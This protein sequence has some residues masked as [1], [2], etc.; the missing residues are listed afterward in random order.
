ML[1]REHTARWLT[2]T[3]AVVLLAAGLLLLPPMSSPVQAAGNTLN[4]SVTK[5][6]D[7]SIAL[8][9]SLILSGG[10]LRGYSVAWG[11]VGGDDRNTKSVNR[12]T[13]TNIS[14][15]TPGTEYW[16]EIDATLS[17][18]HVLSNKVTVWTTGGSPLPDAPTGLVVT[19]ASHSSVSLQWVDNS[20][21][22]TLFKI[23]RALV[24]TGSFAEID[25]VGAGFTNY[26][27]ST[28][29][30]ST[31]YQYRVCAENATGDSDDSN[32]VAVTTPAEP[33]TLP[34]APTGLAA[35]S[36]AAS[37]VNLQ[38][39]DNSSNETLFK[40]ERAP[41]SSGSFVQINTAS[42]ES[43]TYA[44]ATVSASTGYRYRVLASNSAGNSAYSNTV[45]VTTPAPPPTRPAAPTGLVL[46]VNAY[47][48]VDLQWVD[49][50]SDETL[51]KIERAPAST[52]VFVQINT[53][54]A[55]SIT[56]SDATVSASTAYLYRVCANNTAGN[57]IYSNTLAVTTPAPPAT[58][59][60]APTNLAVTANAYNKVDL[61]WADNS[62][63]ETL[64]KV[65]RAPAS[66]G[67][68][69]QIDTTAAGTA[70]YSDAA[71][72]ASTSY[73][74]RVCA[75]NTAGNSVYSNTLAVTTPA[76]P[77]TK[78]AAPTGLVLKANAYNKVDLQWAD[79]S[80]DETLFKVERAPASTGVF[81]QINTTAAGTAV[82]SDAAVSASTSY[83]YRV[84][85]YNTAGNSVY[86]NT[87][88]VTT[89]ASP[90]VKP[91]APTNL[92]ATAAS[93]SEIN[94]TWSDTSANETGFAIERS[95]MS[96]TG[97]S[98][99][100]TVGADVKTYKDVSL[101][102]GT[103]YYYRVCSVN[104]GVNSDYSAVASDT[105][106]LKP[107]SNLSA[108]A[109]SS[110]SISLTW[111][112]N[113]QR[114]TSYVVERSTNGV[115]GP[116]QATTLPANTTTY[117]DQSCVPLTQYSYRVY[118]GGSSS[119]LYSNL[120]SLIID[121]P[122]QPRWVAK[123]PVIG[124]AYWVAMSGPYAYV[125]S[126][127]GLQV[128]DIT[129]PQNP[130]V[131]GSADISYPYDVATSGD[132]FVYVGASRDL[133]VV[134]VRDPT[135]P[136][137]VAT[138]AMP[139]FVFGLC[140]SDNKLYVANYTAGLA[141][142][143]IQNRLA[144]SMLG[145]VDTVGQANAVSVEGNLAVVADGS[146]G[147]LTVNVTDP[148]APVLAGS[149]ATPDYALDVDLRQG[150]A[151]VAART[152]G[153]LAVGVADSSAPQLL[154]QSRT[155]GSAAGVHMSDVGNLA[156]IA[157]SSYAI[158]ANGLEIHDLTNPSAPLRL[159]FHA[160]AGSIRGGVAEHGG[161]A[162]LAARTSGLTIID[163][164]N[165][166]VP[167]SPSGLAEANRSYGV[168]V[169][170]NYLYA[171]SQAS[172]YIYD[173][174]QTSKPASVGY[175]RM[176][177]P[178]DVAVSGDGYAFVADG[179]SLKVVDISD[180]ANPDLLEDATVSLDDYAFGVCISGGKAYVAAYLAGLIIVDISDP[181][182]PRKL[183]SVDTPGQA[184][185]VSASGNL[186]AIADGTGGL[187]IVDAT[188]SLKP[189]IAGSFQTPS[190]AYDVAIDQG[191]AY[192]AAGYSG[193]QVVSLAQPKLPQL[194]GTTSARG[195]AVGIC[196]AGSRAFVASSSYSTTGNG[197]QV[198]DISSPSSPVAQAFLSSG[199]FSKSVAVS[200]RTV[201]LTD[202]KCLVD[203][204]EF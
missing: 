98:A 21:N 142:V 2:A 198:F 193:L 1:K 33:P 153:V 16:F 146:G 183:G 136:A 13:M 204:G 86:S 174:T 80:S 112:D 199:I 23:E 84:C 185:A 93:D 36:V 24:S 92:S 164:T 125:T 18:G 123:T 70:T 76:A 141:I 68:F 48:K 57:S 159:S 119:G 110:N 43:T 192:I 127:T 179:K 44:D 63:D 186:V 155:L 96:T 138:L 53:A 176:E 169:N 87:L 62:S 5:A 115:S 178:Y 194:V 51:F 196:L 94:L 200:G 168:T 9:W 162:C 161:I 108:V 73:L 113:S 22:E 133:K 184:F 151:Y 41:A 130:L 143:D 15:L 152:A 177:S 134:D 139:D 150:I 103:T 116:W 202:D 12:V 122:I 132:G 156:Y 149:L 144:P 148:R 197:L 8:K 11:E 190:N 165:P 160:V 89:P 30:A 25:T 39:V 140:V 3:L 82:Y 145:T 180:P 104:N 50:S 85:A 56:Y 101:S 19:A 7:T 6:T 181:L 59:P 71:V 75:Y 26:S 78:P 114:E 61:Q 100:K 38:W 175:L 55:E 46:K 118:A 128:V 34:V 83:L 191:R 52:G 107:P 88:A 124:E 65:E 27:D 131:T 167:F 35:T 69:V 77:P 201:F 157:S 105:T 42:A 31:A 58:K 17:T 95:T 54:V 170:A 111:A 20:S 187:Q 203:I 154:G 14:P 40:I 28:V 81:V 79:N 117:V 109:T 163:A 102:E 91:A 121:V 126:S 49:N 32:T 172:L 195:S 166:A 171:T 129:D 74:Y 99:V 135:N 47:N 10:V 147:M 60:A 45:T 120:A 137:V 72:S 90:P 66:T 182:H 188:D 29:S 189:V 67:V 37:N 106:M 97:F 64:F 158:T 4:L 173:L